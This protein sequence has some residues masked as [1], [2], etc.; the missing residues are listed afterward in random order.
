MR[1]Q[2]E[3]RKGDIKRNILK[4]YI[5]RRHQKETLKGVQ[6]KDTLTRDPKRRA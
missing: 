5:K 1:H 2:K 6:L 3:T 4:G